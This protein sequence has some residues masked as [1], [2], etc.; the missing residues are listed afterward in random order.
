MAP[1]LAALGLSLVVVIHALWIPLKAEVA[2]LLLHD[3]WARARHGIEAPRPWPWADT[4]P[5]ARLTSDQHDVDLFVLAGAS[6]SS[7]AFGP[8]H[9]DGTALPGE[10]GNAAVG[11]HRDTSFAF[12][13][14]L[15]LGD[16]L[17]VE[18]PAG[19]LGRYAVVETAIVNE[20]DT[21]ALQEEPGRA[22]TLIT[23]WPFHALAPGGS[24][25][26]VVRALEVPLLPEA[27]GGRA[28]T[29]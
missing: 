6:G 22:L 3:A 12:L 26:Y 8:G 21:R 28:R 20:R 15:E 14:A 10:A 16:V 9:V 29:S 4:W 23:C 27:P 17:Q 11:G 19:E 1:A 18:T 25:R 5:V 24:D 13:E 7:L 2:Q